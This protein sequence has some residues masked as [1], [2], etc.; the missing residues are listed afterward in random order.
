M[1]LRAIS[2][3]TIAVLYLGFLTLRTG[4]AQ[5][6]QR[7]PSTT[8]E[9]ARAV[10]VAHQLEDDP[11]GKDT[12]KERAWVM[13]WIIEIPDIVVTVCMDY[14][15]DLPNPPRGH[16]REITQQMIISSAA[17]MVEHPDKAKDEQ[18]VALTGLMGALK[19][20]QAILKQDP[21]AHWPYMDKVLQMRDQGNLDDYVS[22]TRRK[23]APPQ[24]DNPDRIRAQAGGPFRALLTQARLVRVTGQ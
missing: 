6:Q 20:Y 11:L 12:Q 23:C 21:G 14:F 3:T 15:G 16:S 5:Q 19:A 10:K 18:A 7:G 1:K 24:D 22:D 8:E 4:G 2:A 13:K 17:F 9:R